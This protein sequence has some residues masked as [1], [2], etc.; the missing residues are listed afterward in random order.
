MAQPPAQTE[1]MARSLVS[2]LLATLAACGGGGSTMPEREVA[3]QVPAGQVRM[4]DWSGEPAAV[5]HADSAML[6]DLQAQTPHTWSERPVSGREATLVLSLTSPATGC[7]LMHAP[8]AEPRFAP[9][10]EWQGGFYDPCRFGEW[11]YAGRAIRQYGDQP[12]S[13]RLADLSV[14]SSR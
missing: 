9:E 7:T 4:L 12:E 1:R 2:A 14:L 3:Q 11:D 10:R 6:D 13:M 8:R 5:V